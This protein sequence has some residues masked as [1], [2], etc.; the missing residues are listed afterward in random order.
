MNGKKV[1][2]YILLLFLVPLL[3]LLL[4][5]GV[6]QFFQPTATPKPTS[7]LTPI[8]PTVSSTPTIT[9][10]YTLV[11]TPTLP[12]AVPQPQEGR[13]VVVG[14][15]VQAGKAVP[16]M[17]V[18]LC[19]DFFPGEYTAYTSPC[20]GDKYKVSTNQDGYYIFHVKPGSFDAILVL[21]PGQNSVLAFY[22]KYG[23]P[24]ISVDVGETVFLGVQD[25]GSDP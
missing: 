13:A 16:S 6:T 25:I 15:I 1:F 21:L 11:P 24:I 17:W 5:C 8:P 20:N 18:Q 4:G 12:F 9:P 14:Q 22:N 3:L 23:E 10:T 19:G 7:T 2:R